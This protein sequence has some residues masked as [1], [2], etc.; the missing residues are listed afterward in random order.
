MQWIRVEIVEQPSES[1]EGD[2][3]ENWM[4]YRMPK[5]WLVWAAKLNGVWYVTAGGPRSAIVPFTTEQMKR[6]FRS[7]R[8]DGANVIFADPAKAAKIE[9]ELQSYLTLLAV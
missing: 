3:P 1:A 2:L 6:F 7:V 9:H 8:P 5:G 4:A